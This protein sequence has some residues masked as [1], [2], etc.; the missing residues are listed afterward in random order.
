MNTAGL[1]LSKM[2]FELSGWDDYDPLAGE[3]MQWHM[4][5]SNERDYHIAPKYD[6]GYL[7][8]KLPKSTKQKGTRYALVLD[9][10]PDGLA[11]AEYRCYRADYRAKIVYI[12]STIYHNT[13]NTPEDAACRL[14]VELFKEGVLE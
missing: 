2:L 3:D 12:D 6:L 14:A 1:E 11:T 8:R 4:G 7:L 10:D 5:H 13:A 9:F